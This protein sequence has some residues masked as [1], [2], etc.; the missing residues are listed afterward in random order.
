MHKTLKAEAIRPP[1][2]NLAAQ[3]RAFTVFRTEFNFER[4]TV[5]SVAIRPPRAM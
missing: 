2:G 5:R 4:R 3:P 1:K